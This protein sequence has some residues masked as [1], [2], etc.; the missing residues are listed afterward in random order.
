MDPLTLAADCAQRLH[1]DGWMQVN[2]PGSARFGFIVTFN[3]PERSCLIGALSQWD[4]PTD[5]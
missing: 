3:I 2:T 1:D 4:N 5:G